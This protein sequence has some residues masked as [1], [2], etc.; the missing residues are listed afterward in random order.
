MPATVE[1]PLA[2][3]FTLPGGVTYR[4]RLDDLPKPA[5]GCTPGGRAGCGDTPAWP[6]PDP[7]GRDAVRA[8]RPSDG[9]RV[10]VAA[11]RARR[12]RLR[13]VLRGQD[14]QSQGRAARAGRRAGVPRSG[15]T[16]AVWKLDR[17]GRSVREV[18]T[19]ADE[20]YERGIGVRILTGTLAGSYTPT[21]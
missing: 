1:A 21:G 15:D 18:L 14:L 3:L 7:V 5:A 10:A 12:G 6:D 9:A 16:L 8:D 2:V 13:E 20:L 19:L 17:L 11:R 4:R